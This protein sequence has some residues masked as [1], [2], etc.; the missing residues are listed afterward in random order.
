[1]AAILSSNYTKI[2]ELIN[3]LDNNVVIA[4]YNSKNQTIISGAENDVNRLIILL[5]N[6]KFKVIPLNVSGAFHSPLMNNVKKTLDKIITK[7][8]FNDISLPIYQNVNP[9]KN[10]KSDLVKSNLIEQITSPVKWIDIINNMYN[11][12]NPNFIEVGPGSVLTKLNKNI[13]SDIICTN[14]NKLQSII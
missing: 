7:T 6:E 9:K 2:N 3:H 11:D 5:K 13:N 4:N 10:F 14:F 1:M 12:G 8:I